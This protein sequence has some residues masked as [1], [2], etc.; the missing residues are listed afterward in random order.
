MSVSVVV[1]IPF[2]EKYLV[3]LN[4]K[5]QL[6]EQILLLLLIFSL[7]NKGNK[8]SCKVSNGAGISSESFRKIPR[9]HISEMRPI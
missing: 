8:V 6:I 5:L 9:F 4:L 3:H 2:I 7:C 1:P